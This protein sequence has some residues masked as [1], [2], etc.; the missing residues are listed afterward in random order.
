M[1]SIEYVVRPKINPQDKDAAPKYYA[2]SQ[3]KGVTDTEQMA[4]IIAKSSTYMESDVLG[5]LKAMQQVI[6]ESLQ[7]GRII[8]LGSLGKFQV[9][10]NSKGA[11][12]EK[13]FKKTLIKRANCRFNPGAPLILWGSVNFVKVK[14]RLKPTEDD[15]V[16]VEED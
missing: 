9:T 5:V 1:A 15:D 6:V 7:Q 8:G 14:G 4:E 12:T 16:V 11:A 10:I 13:D 2:I 3:N